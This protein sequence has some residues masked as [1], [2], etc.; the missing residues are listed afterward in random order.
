LLR[1]SSPLRPWRGPPNAGTSNFEFLQ[2]ARCR[3][4]AASEGL[5]K[6]DTAGIDAFLKQEG[7]SRELPVRRFGQEQ[8]R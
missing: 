7:S 3:G 8:N 5:G 2:A 1:R 4:L 6:V